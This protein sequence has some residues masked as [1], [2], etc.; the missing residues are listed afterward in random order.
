MIPAIDGET[1][2]PVELVDAG[3]GCAHFNFTRVVNSKSF[4][5]RCRACGA[6]RTCDG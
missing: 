1:G 6:L 2:K 5:L 3:D 4:V